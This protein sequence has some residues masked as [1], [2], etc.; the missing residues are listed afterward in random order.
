MKHL[1]YFETA[2]N[3]SELQ[4]D[5]LIYADS[6]APTENPEGDYDVLWTSPT[7]EKI[8]ATFRDT[9]GPIIE[10]GPMGFSMFETVTGSASDGKEYEG[11]VRYKELGKDQTETFQIVSIIIKE[12]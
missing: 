2:L 10:E 7:G 3:E 12:K 4:S 1:K 11:E 8:T 6:W 5:E 9:G